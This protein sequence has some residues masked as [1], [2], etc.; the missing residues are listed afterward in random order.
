MVEIRIIALKNC[1]NKIWKQALQEISRKKPFLAHSVDAIVEESV[2][3]LAVR[4]LEGRAYAE[5]FVG[6]TDPQNR[7][8]HRIK[9]CGMWAVRMK[10]GV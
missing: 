8:I 3:A 5:E 4:S 6:D 7:S 1:M 2:V 10:I 9:R